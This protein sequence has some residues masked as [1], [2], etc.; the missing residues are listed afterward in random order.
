[1]EER[2][3]NIQEKYNDKL[4]YT[5]TICNVKVKTLTQVIPVLLFLDS[6]FFY[7]DDARWGALVLMVE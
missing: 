6:V 4:G 7:T 3:V 5:P 2:L 1:M